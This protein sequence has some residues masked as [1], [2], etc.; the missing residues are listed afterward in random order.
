MATEGKYFFRPFAWAFPKHSPYL[1]SFNFFLRQFSETGAWSSIQKKYQARAQVCPDLSGQPMEWSNCF[2]AFLCLLIGIILAILL[3][4]MECSQCYS[5]KRLE[6]AKTRNQSASSLESPIK[7]SWSTSTINSGF[8]V[9]SREMGC[10]T[11]L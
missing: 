2:T 4:L 3:L 10:Q 9:D 5:D 11:D 1:A 8:K 6:P 7:S